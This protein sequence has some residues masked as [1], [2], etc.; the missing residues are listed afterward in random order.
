MKTK[1]IKIIFPA[2]LLFLALSLSLKSASAGEARVI[3]TINIY[4]S[5]IVSQDGNKLK[6]GFEIFNRENVQPDVRYGILL[7]DEK[8]AIVDEQ[9]Y[10]EALVLNAGQTIKKEI[11]YDAPGYLN[12]KY[13]LWIES[14]NSEGLPFANIP[15][16]EVSLQSTGQFLKIDDNSCNFK[17]SGESE[18]K[19]YSLIQGVD[20]ARDEN[21]VVFCQVRNDLSQD[22]VFQSFVKTYYRSQF[23]DVV[24][25]GKG[26]QESLK[27]GESKNIE[28]KIPKPDKPQ[29]YDLEIS[30]LDPS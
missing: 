12:G 16:G 25:E 23:G 7:Q 4:N 20:V 8:G 27:K 18:D 1:T 11:E 17:I 14:K 9:V 3:A 15:V 30:L 2:M 19:K 13:K 28:I 24:S 10:S 21:L 6:I 5:K 26:D 29:A 22:I